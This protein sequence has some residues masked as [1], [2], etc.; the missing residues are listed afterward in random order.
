MTVTGMLTAMM[1]RLKSFLM[2][3][4]SRVIFLILKTKIDENETKADTYCVPTKAKNQMERGQLISK[5]VTKMSI[6]KIINRIVAKRNYA[7]Y[8]DAKNRVIG[9][10][11]MLAD[12]EQSM[13]EAYLK[14]DEYREAKEWNE[15]LNAYYNDEL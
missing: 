13:W 15:K 2:A 10:Q 5:N 4:C 6:A 9:L 7:R 1:K 12:A 11:Q 14:T 3:D 8:R